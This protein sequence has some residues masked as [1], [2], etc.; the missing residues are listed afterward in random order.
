MIVLFG[1]LSGTES[2]NVEK[3]GQ[4][5]SCSSLNLKPAYRTER[6]CV[7]LCLYLY[8]CIWAEK[9]CNQ[10]LAT[11][12]VIVMLWNHEAIAALCSVSDLTKP[13]NAQNRLPAL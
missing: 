5:E 1:I 2:L 9:S 3:K 8:F 7:C 6:R 12:Q 11:P 13:A 4:S 10:P